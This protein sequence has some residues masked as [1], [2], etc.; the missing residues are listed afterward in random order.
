MAKRDA[1]LTSPDKNEVI[2]SKTFIYTRL[3]GGG[4]TLGISDGIAPPL[5]SRSPPRPGVM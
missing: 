2:P 3:G 4:G 5:T 1:D